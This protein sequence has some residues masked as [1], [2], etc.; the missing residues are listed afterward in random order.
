MPAWYLFYQGSVQFPSTQCYSQSIGQFEFTGKDIFPKC[1]AMNDRLSWDFASA[2]RLSLVNHHCE[3]KDKFLCHQIQE[4][5]KLI[6]GCTVFG[7]K[8]F[9]SSLN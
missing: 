6:T 9:N 8:V 7:I 5:Q 3:T 4:C 2:I 1:P